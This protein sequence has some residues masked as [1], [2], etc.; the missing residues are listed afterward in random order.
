MMPF[1]QGFNVPNNPFAKASPGRPKKVST[2]K[3]VVLKPNPD[4]FQMSSDVDPVAV[5]KV[6]DELLSKW[7]MPGPMSSKR[8]IDPA[9]RGRHISGG[10]GSRY[11]RGQGATNG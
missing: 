5:Q 3:L 10:W 9:G 8:F 4:G 2:G 6:R 11:T 1:Q 7:E